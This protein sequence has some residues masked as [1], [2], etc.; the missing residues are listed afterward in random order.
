LAHVLEEL[1]VTVIFAADGLQG[2]EQFRANPDLSLAFVDVSMPNLDGISMI[3][4][5]SS[6]WGSQ[7]KALPPIIMVT[8]ENSKEMVNRARGA[9]IK[10]WIVKPFSP[11]ALKILAE[12]FAK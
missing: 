1:G 5:L 11:D 2:I 6:E 10:G 3:E 7:G 12:K 4:Q 8:T 9:G